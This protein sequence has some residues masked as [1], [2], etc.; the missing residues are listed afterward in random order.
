MKPY[1]REGVPYPYCADAVSGLKSK[2]APPKT[3][4][5]ANRVITHRA[6]ER[7]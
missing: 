5:L 7:G 2:P 3:R 4:R 1:P 6:S